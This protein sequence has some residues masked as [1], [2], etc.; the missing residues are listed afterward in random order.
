MF[1]IYKIFLGFILLNIPGL[2]LANSAISP[3]S[4]LE[5]NKEDEN[6]SKRIVALTSLTADIVSKINNS[7]LVGIP[8][9]SLTIKNKELSNKVI[10]SQGRTPP[11]IEK[12]ISLKPDLV[13]GSN[14]FHKKQ[15]KKL[16]SIGIRSEGV[17]VRN[18]SDLDKLISNLSSLTGGNS[19]TAQKYLNNCKLKSKNKVNNEVLVLVSAKPLLAPNSE[20]WA[21]NLLERFNINNSTKLLTDK[22]EFKGYVNLSPEWLVSNQ[23][24][25]IILVKTGPDSINSFKDLPYWRKLNAVKQN[26]VT[27]MDYYGLINPG[28]L[29]SINNTCLTLSKISN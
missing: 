16:S 6:I 9:S 11:Q 12:I 19:L 10:V 29:D 2:V 25:K 18:W 24:D 7:S 3:V 13:L 4:N 20:S 17:E 23:P 27:Y 5:I 22:S 21:G 14:S 15:L 26:N 28:S 1:N 8:G